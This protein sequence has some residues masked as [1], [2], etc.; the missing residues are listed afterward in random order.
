MSHLKKQCNNLEISSYDE[1]YLFSWKGLTLDKSPAVFVR[2]SLCLVHCF[3]VVSPLQGID[4]D[5]KGF[6]SLYTRFNTELKFQQD[7]NII[8]IG[9]DYIS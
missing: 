9:L 6:G 5:A 1:L 2:F 7:E 8:S 4:L 3:V